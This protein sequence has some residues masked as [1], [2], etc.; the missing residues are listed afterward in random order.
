LKKFWSR[1]EN[2]SIQA[3]SGEILAV[4]V[5]SD[6]R[7]VVSGGRDNF[8]R[9]YD[10]RINNAEIKCFQGHRDAVTSLAFRKDT[11]TLFSGSLDRSIKHWDLNEVAY[12]ETLFGHQVYNNKIASK[13]IVNLSLY[14]RKE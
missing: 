10:E 13:F 14:F 11:Y 8:V 5:S 7:Y 2:R 12:I 6:G 3:S 1:N 4:T 9:I